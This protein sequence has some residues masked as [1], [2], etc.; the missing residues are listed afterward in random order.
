[1]FQNPLMMAAI[2]MSAAGAAGVVQTVLLQKY[3]DQAWIG[4]PTL[5]A[6]GKPST[7]ISVV[8]G[9]AAIAA[10][11][12]GIRGGSQMATKIRGFAPMLFAYGGTS[13]ATGL[14]AG[15]FASQSGAMARGFPRSAAV[16][17]MPSGYGNVMM[18]SRKRE[19]IL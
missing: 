6:F 3:V 5:G 11:V 1:M 10:G 13:L 4:V 15:Y 18:T 9:A 16:R 2:K 7:L 14:I 12:Y 8:A 19:N 17:A